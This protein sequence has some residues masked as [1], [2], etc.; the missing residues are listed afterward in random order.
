MTL[1]VLAEACYKPTFPGIPNVHPVIQSQHSIVRFKTDEPDPSTHKVTKVAL[2]PNVGN[3]TT[4]IAPAAEVREANGLYCEAVFLVLPG[5][6]AV[7]EV[8]D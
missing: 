3:V 5:G 8:E 1:E 6:K 7:L 4:G 2:V